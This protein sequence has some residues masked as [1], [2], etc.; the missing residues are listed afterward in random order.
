M[1]SYKQIFVKNLFNEEEEILFVGQQ[2]GDL[3]ELFCTFDC[4]RNGWVVVYEKGILFSVRSLCG[5]SL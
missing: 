2:Q 3:V 1:K 5:Y 4:G